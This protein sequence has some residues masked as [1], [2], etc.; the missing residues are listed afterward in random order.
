MNEGRDLGAVLAAVGNHEGKALT[1]LA[2][3][4]GEEYG[5][6]ALH[7]LFLEIQGKEPAFTGQV[8]L[9][10]KYCIHSF[11][12]A[13]LVE[14]TQNERGKR[15]HLKTDDDGTATALAGHLLSV[16]ETHPASL[17]QIFGAT[18]SRQIPG[19]DPERP[20]ERCLAVLRVLAKSRDQ[21]HTADI[22][23]DSGIRD[24]SVA[25]VLSRLTK[26]GLLSYRT[27]PTYAMRSRYQVTTPIRVTTLARGLETAIVSYL[28]SRLAQHS[29]PGP[30]IVPRTDIEDHIRTLPRWQDIT[31]IPDIV[32]KVMVRV[33]ARG[34]VKAIQDYTGQTRHSLIE[35]TSGQRAFITRLTHGID[36]ISDDDA[37]A[38]RDGI[39]K[40]REIINDPVRVHAL[41]A[42]VYGSRKQI[43]NPLSRQEKQR[44]VLAALS[45]GDAI[46]TEVLLERL[47]NGF[48]KPLLRGTLNELVREGRIRGEKQPDGPYKL[49][50]LV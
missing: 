26:A 15:R 17:A 2:M 6:G 40:A 22:A 14:R 29:E 43:V 9:Q 16:T 19:L 44:Q 4:P 21:A 10:Q 18:S 30:L 20:P 35:M 38:V 46:T 48:N 13:R 8:N 3:E 23:R 27:G 45:A 50:H 49:W 5:V 11:E 41:M 34:E 24:L 47:G 1:Y 37:D 39:R 33:V 7:R 25:L 36:R 42:K 28:N 32:Q 31:Q 12:P